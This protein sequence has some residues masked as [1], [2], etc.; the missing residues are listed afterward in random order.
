MIAMN[1]DRHNFDT[2]DALAAALSDR[3]AAELSVAVNERGHAVLA[4]SGGCTPQRFF[5]R[6][7]RA[8]IAWEHIIITLVDERFVPVDDPRSN[9]KLV[10]SVLMQNHAR[11]ARFVGLYVGARTA[12]LA[13]FSAA[14][15]INTLPKPFDAVVLGM[16]ADGHTASF[17]PGGDRLKLAIDRHSRAL[18]VPIHARGLSEARLTL[19]LP[20]LVG[21]RFLA[22]HIEG[23]EKLVSFEQA[24]HN[25]PQM[26]MPVRAVLYHAESPV[27]VFWSAAAKAADKNF[28][29]SAEVRDGPVSDNSP[30]YGEDS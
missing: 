2:P 10:R 9:E 7:S 27:Q 23:R 18:V 11:K 14:H 21:S 13:A 25:G 28:L 3:V 5:E 17:F 30:G 1:I 15:R 4:V 16:G 26:D 22:L 6:L 24:L 19:T 29:D 8:D 12:E 20:L